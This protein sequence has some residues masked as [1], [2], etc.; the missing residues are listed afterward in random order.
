MSLSGLCDAA[1]RILINRLSGDGQLCIQTP[2]KQASEVL[3]KKDL[4]I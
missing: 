2:P 3:F 4:F 1:V